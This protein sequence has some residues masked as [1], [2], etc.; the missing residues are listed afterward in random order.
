MGLNILVERPPNYD[1][2]CEVF[3]VVRTIRGVYFAWGDT[4]YNPDNV[5]IERHIMYH[6]NIHCQRQKAMCPEG[7]EEGVKLWWAK[8][9]VDTEFRYAEEL[10]AHK[11]E[12]SFFRGIC[13]N[14]RAREAVLTNAATRLSS[15]LYGNIVS[16]SA[17]RREIRG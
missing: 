13:R 17:A 9:L 5:R 12:Y 14:A 15:S 4:I 3:P 6:E 8:Y 2:I 1:Q 16:Y 11:A 10:V 7:W